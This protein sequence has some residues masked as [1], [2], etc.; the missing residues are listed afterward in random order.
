[1]A[2]ENLDSSSVKTKVET[3]NFRE[4]LLPFGWRKIG[5]RRG[6]SDSWYFEVYNPNGK[7]FRSNT[8]L[9]KFLENNPQ[10]KCDRKVTNT[11]AK[12]VLDNSPIKGST[13]SKLF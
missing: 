5:H 6:N 9:T 8:E 13:I 3:N 10:V 11:S 7:K 2:V 4:Y 1:M 12:M